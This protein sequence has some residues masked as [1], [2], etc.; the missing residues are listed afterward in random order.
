MSRDLDPAAAPAPNAHVVF[1]DLDG[2]DGV[3]VDLD[4]KQYFQLNETASFVWRGLAER[5]SLGEI[6]RR[7]T[8]AYD[9]TLE[10]AHASVEAVV[11]DFTVRKLVGPSR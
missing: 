1:T 6:A 4:T 2:A 11:K 9:V 3:L 8:G 7:M 5:L 10:D